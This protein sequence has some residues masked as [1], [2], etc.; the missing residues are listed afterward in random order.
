VNVNQFDKDLHQIVRPTLPEF[1]ADHCTA[2]SANRDFEVVMFS[3]RRQFPR[4]KIDSIG[5][6]YTDT[7][8]LPRDCRIIDI[9]IGGARL[10]YENEIPEL[11]ELEITGEQNKR[12]TCKVL[13]R[14]G[15][16]VGVTF[17]PARG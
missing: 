11:F 9:S 1:F 3:D 13:W 12:H 7:G 14:L 15:G 4:Q 17:E 16:E 6:V 2:C 5:K 8:A 10:F